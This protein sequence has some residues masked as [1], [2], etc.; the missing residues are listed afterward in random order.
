MLTSG[1]VIIVLMG[2][3]GAVTEGKKA[4]RTNKPKLML[5]RAVLAQICAVCN[6]FAFQ[7][8]TLA[9]F[10]TLVFTS[11]FWV[12]LLSAFFFKDKL[13]SHRLGVIAFGFAVILFILRPGNEAFNVWWLVVLLTAFVYSCQMLLIRQIG[14]GESRAFMFMS[15]S[16]IS[17]IVGAVFLGDHYVPLSLFEW[18][19]FIGM[20]VIGCI[21]LLSIGYAFQTAPSASIIAPYHYTQIV[22]GAILGHVLFKEELSLDIVIGA[23]LIILSG[24]YLLNHETRKVRRVIRPPGSVS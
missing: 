20:G 21:G 3:Y 24:I 19:L 10:Y 16:V 2:F 17:V 18:A 5:L 15:G 14:A 1:V 12:T 8:V 4:F 13:D 22:W 9:A 11:P 6:L 23:V 7:H